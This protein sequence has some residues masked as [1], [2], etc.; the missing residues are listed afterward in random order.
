MYGSTAINEFGWVY[1]WGNGSYG[2]KG[3]N[4]LDTSLA[5]VKNPLY[6]GLS[7]SMGAGYTKTLIQN[8][9]LYSCRKK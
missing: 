5:P 7:I 4:T 6:A 8:G 9:Y 1:V 2:E 3:N